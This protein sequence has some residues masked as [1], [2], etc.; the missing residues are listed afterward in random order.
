M[1]V[2]CSLFHV[3]FIETSTSLSWPILNSVVCQ[4]SRA[5][6]TC[7]FVKAECY[8]VFYFFNAKL[9][10]IAFFYKQR[11][12]YGLSPYVGL[13]QWT[14]SVYEGSSIPEQF[15]SSVYELRLLHPE[16]WTSSV[17]ESSFTLSSEHPQCMKAPPPWAVNILS[18]WRLLHPEQWTSSVYEGSSTLSSEHPQCMKAPPSWAVNI[19]SVWRLLH[20][21]ASSLLSVW[22]LLHPWE[23]SLSVYE[24]YSIL[25]SR[26]IFGN[27]I[28]CLHTNKPISL[29]HW[30]RS[31]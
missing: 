29:L 25:R 28:I 16:Q 17:Y 14:S 4:T 8:I 19:L 15:T 11:T 6:Y 12:Q 22:R 5:D 1:T 3:Q 20:S 18:E 9:Y 30:F 24:G 10:C 23:S 2:T 26:Q 31:L 27:E 7:T 13:E 21:W